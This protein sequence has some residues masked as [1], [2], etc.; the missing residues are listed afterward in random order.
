MRRSL[1]P[2]QDFTILRLQETAGRPRRSVQVRFA[3]EL[4]LRWA[5]QSDMVE[6]KG[7][8]IPMRANTLDTNV[9]PFETQTLAIGF[10]GRGKH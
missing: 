10:A 2:N 5:A 9:G 1:F 4:G 7:K 6:R 8:K 3:D